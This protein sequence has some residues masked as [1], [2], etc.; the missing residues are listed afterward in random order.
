MKTSI[1]E[2]AA[3]VFR[4][5]LKDPKKP[6]GFN[7]F[8]IKDKRPALIHMG[9]ASTFPHLYDLAAQVIDPSTIRYLAFSHVEAD[10]SGATQKWLDVAP[11]AEVVAGRIAI[12]S[13]RDF[14]EERWKCL[15]DMESAHLGTRSMTLLETPHVPHNWDACLFHLEGD[16]IL[17]SSDLGTQFGEK[18]ALAKT[19]LLDE[20][21]NLQNEIGYI[22]FGPHVSRAIE[23]ISKLKVGLLA[24]MH[25]SSLDANQSQR[26]FK[27]LADSNRNAMS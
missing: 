18:E 27:R 6:L 26:F 16:N 4:L 22:S 2:I 14:V 11:G 19:D 3:N 24:V 7:H 5:T 21:F 15:S 9:H 13:V 10:E 17:F 8:L 1:D 25:G 23:K 12:S 20:I